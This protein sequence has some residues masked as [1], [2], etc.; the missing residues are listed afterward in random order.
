[1]GDKVKEIAIIPCGLLP[2]FILE[3]DATFQLE[4]SKRKN[5]FPPRSS[6]VP[7]ILPI[8]PLVKNPRY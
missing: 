2:T 8:D 7:Y 6:Q 5:V 4:V 1:M 3:G